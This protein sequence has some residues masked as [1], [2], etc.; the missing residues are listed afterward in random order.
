MTEELKIRATVAQLEKELV[1]P[2]KEYPI[3]EA[4]YD[5]NYNTEE[6]LYKPEVFERYVQIYNNLSN[7]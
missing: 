4:L 1:G 6:I 2:N 5:F 7:G 3:E